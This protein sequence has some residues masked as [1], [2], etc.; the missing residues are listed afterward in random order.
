MMRKHLLAFAAFLALLTFLAAP[1]ASAQSG[2]KSLTVAAAA[3]M[4]F[5][6]EELKKEFAQQHP[7]IAVVAVYGSSGNFYSQI[8]N[9]APFD[10]FLSADI[11]YP[12]KLAEQGLADSKSIFQYAVGRIV[13]WVPNDSKIDVRKLGVKALLDPAVKKIAV[14]NPEHAPYGKAA[15]AAMKTLGVYDQAQSR[16]AYGENIA[17]TAQYVATGAAQ[18]GVIALSLAQSPEMSGKGRYWEF[19]LSAYPEMK[20]AGVILKSAKAPD[21][22]ALFRTFMMSQ[23]A[24]QILG[25]YGF[26]V[27]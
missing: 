18:I 24:K 8:A 27:S 10:V 25:R 12:R 14:A 1:F 23:K 17:Q 15:V 16:F 6:L 26:S 2:S 19:P 13:I 22:A 11:E 9:G 20:Q 5:A 3:D 21:A 7:E 4:K